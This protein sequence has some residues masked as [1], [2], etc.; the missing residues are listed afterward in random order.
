MGT[1]PFQGQ[2]L[3]TQAQP[4]NL[5]MDGET[6]L[7]LQIGKWISDI[8]EQ[9]AARIIAGLIGDRHRVL[10]VGPSW[11]RDHYY[12]SHGGKKV[13]SADIAPQRHLDAFLVCDVTRSLPLRDGCFDA[14]LMSEVLEHLVDDAAALAEAR[15]VL[16]DDGLLVVSVPFYDDEAEFHVR[17]HSPRSIRRLLRCTGFE[18]VVHVVRGG[19]ISW[20]RFVHAV[21]RLCRPVIRPERF[22]EGVVWIDHFLSRHC[23][24]LLQRS[25]SYGCYMAARKV[26]PV[27]YKQANVNEFR[28]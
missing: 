10:N 1:A 14:V 26:A 2:K 27:D 3:K 22:N 15:R 25:R 13:I 20:P 11:G 4:T 19:L 7:H 24:W 18:P 23:G 16:Y 8:R 28:H 17:I 6:H 12:L 21:R 9:E 5:H